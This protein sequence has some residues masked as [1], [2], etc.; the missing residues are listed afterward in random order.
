[1]LSHDAHLFV[2]PVRGIR[3]K[4]V[5]EMLLLAALA[6]ENT[7]FAVTL[8]PKN[9]IERGSFDRWRRLA[10]DLELPCRFDT[11]GPRSSGGY[12]CVFTDMVAAADALVTTSIAEGFGMVFMEAW[13]AGRPLIGRDLPEITR[14]FRDAGLSFDGLVES[15]R[16]PRG[17][18]L[19]PE[20][21]EA[22][23]DEAAN[24]ARIAFGR[25]PEHTSPGDWETCD[26]AELPVGAQAEV[27]EVA[28]ERRDELLAANPRLAAVLAEPPT[29]EVAANAAAVRSAYSTDAIGERLIATLRSAWQA[30]PGSS[31]AFDGAAILDHYLASERLLPVRLEA[32]EPEGTLT[33][34]EAVLEPRSAAE[35]WAWYTP[36]DSVS[37][38]ADLQQ[39]IAALSGPL[40]AQPT[41]ETPV[42]PRIDGVRAVMFD[43]YGTLIV[44]GSG[45]ISLASK[46]SRGAAMEAAVRSTLGDAIFDELG[47]DGD[48][49][50]ERLVHAIRAAHAA[51]P[52]EHPEVEIRDV[53]RTLL[54]GLGLQLEP[55]GVERLAVEYECRVNPVWTMPGLEETLDAF[56]EAGL[57]IGIVSNAQFFTPLAIAPLT[58]RSLD[59]LGVDADLSVWSYEQGHAK[60][61]RSLYRLAAEH[62]A[63]AG[64]APGET[65]YVGNDL[66]N[67][68]WPAAEEG[69]RT[70]LFAGDARSLRWRRDDPRLAE[71]RPDAVVTDLR[72]LPA[73]VG[74]GD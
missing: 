54:A 74:V 61:G 20:W 53:W 46:G 8:A 63:A 35:G 31:A 14:E 36:Y 38:V 34:S 49:I 45:D 71:V 65:L 17:V 67:D 6:P 57:P 1:G 40:D 24:E 18:L 32:P 3:R 12:D 16:V 50:V 4:N 30:A 33:P 59:E 23:R 44:S 2:Y 15:V 41:G 25:D 9:P 47:V 22:E 10:E 56:S 29:G 58:G 73:I 68:V 69:F 66:R 42:T 62:L 70:A 37:R 60:P 28:C 51:S 26:F 39:R 64:I 21:V 52:H 48:A 11:G 72:Q 7:H 5:G 43:V 55:R 19:S 13:L 27:I